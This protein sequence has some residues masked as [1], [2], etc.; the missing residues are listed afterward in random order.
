MISRSVLTAIPLLALAACGG[1]APPPAPP[2]PPPPPPASAEPAPDS[3]P[4][5]D[6]TAP[7][8]APQI[9]ASPPVWRVTEGIAT[10]ESVLYDAAADRYLV[11]NINGSPTGVDNNGFITEISGDGKVTK[12]KFIEGGAGKVK[13]D[14]PKGSGISAGVLYVTDITVV[15]KFDA[16][17]GA[18]KGDIPIKD[19]VFLNDIAIAADGRVFVSDSGM[20]MGE[21]GLEPAGAGDA[22]YVIDKGGKVKPIA[23]MKEL[24][25]P[26]GLLVLDKK[27]IV[28]TL[29]ADEV[30]SLSDKGEKQ[31]ITKLPK[32]GLDGLVSFG[33][34][35]FISS[36]QGSVV[37]KGKLGGTFEPVLHGLNAPADIG[38]DSKRNRVLVPRFV[39]NAIEAYDVK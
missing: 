20:K 7:A 37:F 39:D 13:L 12:P 9:P 21:K 34:S 35:L 15:R 26:N 16:K 14:A 30:F 38:F 36:W 28:N 11:S 19:A 6:S 29:G 5:T 17:T 2:P 4:P 1:S 18:P 32:G 25:G 8:A 22:V 31:E 10:P 3:V 24:N 27:L 33:D 23:K